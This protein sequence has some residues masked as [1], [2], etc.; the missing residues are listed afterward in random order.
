MLPARNRRD[1]EEVPAGARTQLEFVWIENVDQAL[2][3]AL[4]SDTSMAPH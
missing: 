4:T 2:A 1:L 3:T